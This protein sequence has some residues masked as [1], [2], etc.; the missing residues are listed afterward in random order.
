MDIMNSIAE[1][2]DV[3]GDA[4]LSAARNI[5]KHMGQG[6]ADNHPELLGQCVT[7]FAIIRTGIRLNEW[8]D[9][10]SGQLAD[11][12]KNLSD[13]LEDPYYKNQ[14]LSTISSAVE[15]IAEAI[16]DVVKEKKL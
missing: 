14:A 3:L 10:F 8:I 12:L 11:N 2:D 1:T 13:N 7:A 15:D 9:N 5:D 16:R 6:Y 4:I